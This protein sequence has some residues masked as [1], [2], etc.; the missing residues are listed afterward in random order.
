M[1]M[2]LMGTP[3]TTHSIVRCGVRRATR[4]EDGSI[5]Q[6][7]VVA[8]LLARVGSRAIVSQSTLP[9][10]VTHVGLAS[11]AVVATSTGCHRAR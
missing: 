9:L 4:R 11:R 7:T 5:V 1:V 8:K 3:A 6:G 10:M 2:V